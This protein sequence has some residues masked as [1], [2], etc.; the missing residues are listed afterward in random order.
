MKQHIT[1][2]KEVKIETTV[3]AVYFNA[4]FSETAK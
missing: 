4:S 3:I 2:L 1:E